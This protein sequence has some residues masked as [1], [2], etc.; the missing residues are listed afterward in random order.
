LLPYIAA[1][2]AW[3][4]DSLVAPGARAPEPAGVVAARAARAKA[5]A[6]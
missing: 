5:A 4:S 3:L 2:P 1:L 6:L